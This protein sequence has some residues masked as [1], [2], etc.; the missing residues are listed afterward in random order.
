[1]VL[2]GM[3]QH[4]GVAGVQEEGL[5]ALCVLGDLLGAGRHLVR[6]CKKGFSCA[7]AKK[8]WSHFTPKNN[9]CKS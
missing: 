9:F 4:A 3:K 1:M 5:G 2:A 6:S 7:L 8:N